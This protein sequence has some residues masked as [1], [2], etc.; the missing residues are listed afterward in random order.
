[1]GNQP[2]I[3]RM[4]FVCRTHIMSILDFVVTADGL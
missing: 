2:L 4:G 3:V 1:M